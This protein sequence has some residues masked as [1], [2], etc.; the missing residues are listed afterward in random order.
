M[1]LK[2]SGKR[3]HKENLVRSWHI[4]FHHIYNWQNKFRVSFL[5]FLRNCGTNPQEAYY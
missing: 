1:V 4:C 2:I 5:K 3:Q